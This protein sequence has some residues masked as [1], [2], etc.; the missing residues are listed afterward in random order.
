M[1]DETLK[2][3]TIA[4]ANGYRLLQ[5]INMFEAED[6][7]FETWIAS[8]A[9][10]PY[11]YVETD[12]TG[13]AAHGNMA[14]IPLPKVVHYYHDVWIAGFWNV[15][16]FARVIL[17]Q[18]LAQLTMRVSL[19]PELAPMNL[20]MDRI[21]AKVFSQVDAMVNDICASI[22]Y[23]LGRV[24]AGG[25]TVDNEVNPI[26]LKAISGYTSI[27]PLRLALMVETLSDFQRKYILDQ[28][29]H[30]EGSMGIKQA[31]PNV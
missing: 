27:W 12:A 2:E 20:R 9:E 16:R 31:K 22:P 7:A 17:L 10:A 21:R 25:W 14:G 29:A 15:Y 19:Y 28:L 8:C 18:T 11:N 1:A 24:D 3:R 30:I 26:S 23:T 13:I 4:E 5:I 6:Q